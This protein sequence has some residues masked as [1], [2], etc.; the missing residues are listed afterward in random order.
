M[1]SVSGSGRTPQATEGQGRDSRPREFDD[2][3]QEMPRSPTLKAFITLAGKIPSKKNS[4]TPIVRGGKAR[5]IK[6]S[7]LV[8]EL[9]LLSIQIPLYCRTL[10]LRHPHIVM[11]FYVDKR[12]G[13]RRDR[14]NL[15]TCA[16][17]LLVQNGVLEDDRVACNNGWDVCPPVIVG[18]E[19]KTEIYL[20]AGEQ[21]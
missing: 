6:N 13:T 15:K 3:M 1:R 16:L 7:K 5:M 10:K 9:E 4:Y 19:N 8:G 14:D 20:Y 12:N 21:N 11:Q 17:D 18:K 2:F